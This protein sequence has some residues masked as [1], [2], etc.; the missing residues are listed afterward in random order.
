MGTASAR[1]AEQVSAVMA[2]VKSLA[3]AALRE[4]KHAFSGTLLPICYLLL[5]GNRN[6][7]RKLANFPLQD[8]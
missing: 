5:I 1:V 4:N 8:L 6:K 7:P 3:Q 2:S